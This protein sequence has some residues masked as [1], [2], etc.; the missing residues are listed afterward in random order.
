MR[1]GCLLHLVQKV[2][3]PLSSELLFGMLVCSGIP[4]L[5]ELECWFHAQIDR[6][7]VIL[8]ANGHRNWLIILKL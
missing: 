3:T 5:V 1:K 6:V 4:A 2:G 8:G 7:T